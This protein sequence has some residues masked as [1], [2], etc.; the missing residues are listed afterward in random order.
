[1][2][3]GFT[4]PWV[5]NGV[6]WIRRFVVQGWILEVLQHEAES[7]K[8]PFTTTSSSSPHSVASQLDSLPNTYQPL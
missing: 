5:W 2:V 8:V 7:S 6:G 3:M 1:M 4:Y